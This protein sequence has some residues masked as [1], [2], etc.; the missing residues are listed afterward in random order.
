MRSGVPHR[1]CPPDQVQAELTRLCDEIN[2]EEFKNYA[3]VTQAAY[4]H[5]CLA[6]IHP[7]QD[8]N[9]RVCRVFASLFLM[10]EFKV[11][12]VVYADR[13]HVYLQALEAA[14]HGNYSLL[15]QD[16]VDR[17][18]ATL[19]ELTQIVIGLNQAK[20]EERLDTLLGLIERHDAVEF[21]N[22]EEFT[23]S[24]GREFFRMV[25]EGLTRIVEQ[26]KGSLTFED[27]TSSAS[28]N[29]ISS[30]NGSGISSG[31]PEDNAPH[32]FYRDSQ[33]RDLRLVIEGQGTDISA[34]AAIGAGFSQDKGE[35]FPFAVAASRNGYLHS[36]NRIGFV[37]K[38]RYEDCFPTLA[39][40]T[41]SRIQTLADAVCSDMLAR[42]EEQ[43]MDRLQETGRYLD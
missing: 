37:I 18:V 1:Y 17:V 42:V 10:R 32:S 26:S 2:S 27:N 22:A 34:H 9:G 28:F 23:R 40:N 5:Y 43:T 12:L 14:Q 29:S 19:F 6:Q 21:A 31:L 35:R 16:V 41:L 20:P 36:G 24:L 7:F 39:T 3:T 8:G 15:V 38:L 11:P 33:G 25:D 13:R 30:Y 4:V